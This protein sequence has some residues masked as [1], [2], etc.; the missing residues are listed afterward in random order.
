[1]KLFLNGSVLAAT[2]MALS[3][4][5]LYTPAADANTAAAFRVM[6]FSKTLGYR[7]D[8][9]TNGIEAI[10]NLG[11]EHGFAV[12]ATEDSATLT[13]TNLARYRAIV[14]RPRPTGATAHAAP[15]AP[16]HRPANRA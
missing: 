8:S 2:L 5:P 12:Y 14:C 6:V 10:S 3:I 16:R 11:R 4:T 15:S 7:H 1:M 13:A 9:I